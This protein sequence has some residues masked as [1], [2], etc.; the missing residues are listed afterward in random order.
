VPEDRNTA[1]RNLDRALAGEQLVEEAYSGEVLRTRHYFQVSHC[2]IITDHGEIVG[3]AVLAQDLS[4]R[5]RVELEIHDRQQQLAELAELFRKD[6]AL[7]GLESE[8][9]GHLVKE[10]ATE[11]LMAAM[12]SMYTG[13]PDFYSGVIQKN[14]NGFAPVSAA[15]PDRIVPALTKREREV[16]KLTAEGYN[17]KEIAFELGVSVKMIETHRKHIKQKL[18]L[19]NVAQLVSYAARTGLISIN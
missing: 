9:R 6:T 11:E 12:S 5:K 4:E 15:A 13:K 10:C 7:E 18:K 2:P 19:K 8:A 14:I 1:R 16:L 3:V 17:T